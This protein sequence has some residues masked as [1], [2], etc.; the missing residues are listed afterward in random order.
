MGH[1]SCGSCGFRWSCLFPQPWDFGRSGEYESFAKPHIIVKAIVRNLD[2]S[3]IR[4]GL[5]PQPKRFSCSRSVIQTD[6]EVL[7][8][9]VTVA[10]IC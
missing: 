3:L 10:T 9:Q 7:G 8:L 2:S 4:Q 6:Y 1:E 5:T